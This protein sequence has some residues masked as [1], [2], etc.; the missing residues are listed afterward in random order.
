MQAACSL[1]GIEY[2]DSDT[3]AIMWEKLLRHIELF[4][5]PEI[6]SMAKTKGHD[7]IFT[8][9]YYSDLQPIEFVWA[10]VKGQV[11]RQYTATTTFQQVRQ[12][13]DVVFGE[14]SERSI[15]GCIDKAR[16]NLLD[17]SVHIKAQ[18]EVSESDSDSSSESDGV[19]S[20]NEDSAT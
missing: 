6:V 7:V 11:G 14:I 15:Q 4:V 16:A 2:V 19:S 18:D 8:P 1:Y 17:L 20:A 5:D 9:P 13:L 12:R 10:S 3:R